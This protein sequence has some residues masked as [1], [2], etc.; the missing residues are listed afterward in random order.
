VLAQG[1][2]TNPKWAL[3]VSRDPI[4]NFGPLSS[5]YKTGEAMHF[6]F[7]MEIDGGGYYFY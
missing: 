5:I 4:L 1:H 7:S 3:W 2:K 6:N